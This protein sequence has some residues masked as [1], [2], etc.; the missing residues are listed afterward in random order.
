MIKVTSKLFLEDLPNNC[1]NKILINSIDSCRITRYINKNI[2][3][4][5]I[6]KYYV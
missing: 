2:Y 6:K 5:T 4:L 1:I 3:G